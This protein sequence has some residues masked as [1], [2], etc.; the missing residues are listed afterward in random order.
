MSEH[1]CYLCSPQCWWGRWKNCMSLGP[2]SHRRS[3]LLY[4]VPRNPELQW[5]PARYWNLWGLIKPPKTHKSQTAL[6]DSVGLRHNQGS[7]PEASFQ[8]SWHLYPPARSDKALCHWEHFVGKS[9]VY[10][11]DITGGSV[12][13]WKDSKWKLSRVLHRAVMIMYTTQHSSLLLKTD[14]DHN[15]YMTIWYMSSKRSSRSISWEALPGMKC[16]TSQIVLTCQY[17]F[18]VYLKHFVMYILF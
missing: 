15:K 13:H 8:G 14:W 9:W 10:W 4:S 2:F 3:V 12:F 11:V 17:I 7:R 5:I 16:K 1:S 18:R 6:L